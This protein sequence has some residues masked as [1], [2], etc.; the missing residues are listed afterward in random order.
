MPGERW[1]KGA[2]QQSSNKILDNVCQRGFKRGP[3]V[4]RGG[5]AVWSIWTW[6][7]G[8]IEGYRGFQQLGED[9]GLYVSEKEPVS[10]VSNVSTF[11][12]IKQCLYWNGYRHFYFLKCTFNSALKRKGDKWNMFQGVCQKWKFRSI[13][14]V[15]VYEKCMI[16]SHG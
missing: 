3:G 4:V 13:G 1:K 7:K 10:N 15:L 2:F 5:N 6:F 16:V 8:N 11:F 12:A 14:T 9:W